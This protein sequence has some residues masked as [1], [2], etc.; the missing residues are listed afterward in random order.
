M[1][2]FTCTLNSPASE[3]AVSTLRGQFPH[4]PSDYF[5]FL[6]RSDGG[7][8]FLGISPGYFVIWSAHEVVQF[9]REYELHIYLPGYV[10]VGSSGGGELFVLPIS[11]SPVGLFMVPA[12]GMAPDV[13][14][15]VAPTFSQF[16]AAFG[17]EW[18]DT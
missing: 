7:E 4:L 1:S 17:G 3:A 8:G 18:I 16:V 14:A 6:L 13:V 10:C 11:G 15:I 9:T 2:D 12:I 5:E